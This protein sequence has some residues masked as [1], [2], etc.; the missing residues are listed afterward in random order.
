MAFWNAPIEVQDHRR[1]ACLAAIAAQEAMARLNRDLDSSVPEPPMIRIGI[2]SGKM[3]VGL[4]GSEK[5]LQYT[6]IGD[7]VN[8]ASRLE[9][10]N[11]FFGSRIIASEATYLSAQSSIEARELGLVQVVGKAAPVKVYEI[12][13]RKEVLSEDWKTALPLYE[14][15]LQKFHLRLYS[16]AAEL[17]EQFLKIFPNDG[18]VAFYLAASRDYAAIPPDPSWDGVIKLTAK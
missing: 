4:T 9:G 18:P 15:A 13:G 10:A 1:Q 14:N 8:L 16:E 11:K 17:F 3:T 5:K 12:I 2:N 6:V 7:E